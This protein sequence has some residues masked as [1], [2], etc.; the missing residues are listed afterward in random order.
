MAII[1]GIWPARCAN[2]RDRRVFAGS[3]LISRSGTTAGAIIVTAG[4]DRLGI[5]AADGARIVERIEHVS[6]TR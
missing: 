3:S 6:Q 1:T 2:W 4:D 5:S